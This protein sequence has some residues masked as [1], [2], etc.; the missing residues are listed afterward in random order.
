[1]K[2]EQRGAGHQVSSDGRYAITPDAAGR[3]VSW[4]RDYPP[5][6]AWFVVGDYATP[7]DARRAVDA[8]RALEDAAREARIAAAHLR[9]IGARTVQERTAA[10]RAMQSEIASRSARAVSMVERAQGL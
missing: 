5:A 10:W 4:R 1:M 2:W 8:D 3:W 7:D 9:L 6:R